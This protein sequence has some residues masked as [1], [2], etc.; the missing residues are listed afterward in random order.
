MTSPAA[1][2]ASA[3]NVSIG[4]EAVP[5]IWYAPAET[6]MFIQLTTTVIIRYTNTELMTVQSYYDKFS[7]YWME[8]FQ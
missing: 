4:W 6:G 7:V 3:T 8:V 5:C 1:M 2:S